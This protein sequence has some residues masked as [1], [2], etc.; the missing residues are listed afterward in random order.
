[1]NGGRDENVRPEP[2]R[3]FAARLRPLYEASGGGP[4]VHRELSDAGH[5]PSEADWHAL[6]SGAVTFLEHALR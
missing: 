4:L 6:W 5:F 3:D 2:A 1:V